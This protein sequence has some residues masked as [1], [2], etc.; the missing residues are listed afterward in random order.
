VTETTIVVREALEH[1][2]DEVGT[3]TFLGFGHGEP[4][5]V[6]PDAARESLLRDARTRAEQGALLVAID[7][8]TARIVGT[9]TLLRPGAPLTRQSRDGET[10][11]R[12]LAV[13]PEARR[14][15]AGWN[16]MTAAVET[17]RRWARDGGPVDGVV[18][19]TGPRNIRSQRLYNRLGFERVPERETQP[20]SQGGFLV[21][22]RR[23]LG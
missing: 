15:G 11:V 2:Y 5:A 20:A 14:L 18:L 6:R 13:L 17:A 8:S 22:Y 1:E 21:V 3:V 16:L 9:A 7:E 23:A 10:E 19:D 4:G 12:L